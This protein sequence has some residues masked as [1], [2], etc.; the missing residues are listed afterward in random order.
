MSE[1]IKK[2]A[3]EV[4]VIPAYISGMEQHGLCFF[5]WAESLAVGG[6]CSFC[7]T[8][9]WTNSR[10]NAVL[11]E[12]RPERVSPSGQDYQKYYVEKVQRFLDSLPACPSCGHAKFDLLINNVHFP[13]LED[14]TPLPKNMT[15][16]SL[17][18]ADMESA[19]VWWLN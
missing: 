18:E 10:T 4:G 1:Y 11:G 8:I 6:Q 16:I 2:K 3:S 12:P 7:N 13:R 5:T 9:V 15:D 19:R 17:K 14:G